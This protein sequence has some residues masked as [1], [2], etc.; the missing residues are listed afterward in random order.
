MS[1]DDDL[2]Y[3]PA[4]DTLGT[5]EL[6]PLPEHC[7]PLDAIVLVKALDEDGDTSWYTRYTRD[8][9]S[10]ESVGALNVAHQL[11]LQG[12]V[13]A[14]IPEWEIGLDIDGDDF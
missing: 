9:S 2:E 12:A 3:A 11:A 1:D 10:F 6:V 5:L 14:Y 13:D 7:I 8:L 4:G